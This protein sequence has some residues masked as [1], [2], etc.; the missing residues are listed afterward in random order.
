METYSH[1]L[2]SKAANVVRLVLFEAPSDEGTSGILTGTEK[3]DNVSVCVIFGRK[4]LTKCC[5][6]RLARM[7]DGWQRHHIHRHQSTSHL[8]ALPK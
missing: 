4:S 5:S 2:I 3:E 6:S 8:S 1:F 7:Y